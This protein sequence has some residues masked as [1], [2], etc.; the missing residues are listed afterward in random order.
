MN[1]EA[2]SWVICE[3]IG[4]QWGHVIEQ[5]RSENK[6][7]LV[8]IRKL[9][10]K[11]APIAFQVSSRESFSIL[12]RSDQFQERL[13]THPALDY[14]LYLSELH[15]GPSLNYEEWKLH[16]SFLSGM[17][18]ELIRQRGYSVKL[19]S[20]LD[21]KGRLHLNGGPVS[22]DFGASQANS[23]AQLT[24]AGSRISV[25]LA[26]KPTLSVSLNNIL[27]YG[28]QKQMGH[29]LVHSSPQVAPGMYVESQ[30]W[31]CNHGVVMHGLSELNAFELN[32]FS[33]VIRSAISESS[34]IEPNFALE[35][36]DFVRLLIPLNTPDKMSSVS[37]S[38]MNMRG[39]ICLSYS[40][41]VVLQVETLI[42][43]FSHQKINFL[44][45]IDPLIEPG[46]SGQV[47]YSPWRNDARRLRGLL[48]GAHAFINVAR[49]LHRRLRYGSLLDI[50]NLD[51]MRNVALRVLQCELAMRT[52]DRFADYTDFGKTFSM[53]L[54]QEIGA[55]SFAVLRYPKSIRDEAQR[56]TVA[57]N[58]GT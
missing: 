5:R 52:M 31:L 8:T 2:S 56:I 58:G 44:T 40:D 48:L 37:S 45:A 50:R 33:E 6:K 19:R 29:C 47:Y 34:R 10:S 20:A 15:I 55:L 12:L 18:A 14:W 28:V 54:Q 35:L 38:Y 49:H 22:F 21:P 46:Q 57:H 9:C 13:L 23:D 11:H 26:S 25:K 42:H 7:R 1:L 27:P 43:E 53:R 24:I 39:A 4:T 36:A 41:S 17:A 16:L 32:K 3:G 51:V 30:S